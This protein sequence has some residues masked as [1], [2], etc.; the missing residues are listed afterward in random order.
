MTIAEKLYNRGYISYPRTETDV[1]EF[2]VEELKS[3]IRKQSNDP[4]FGSYSDR[5]LEGE[6]N[7]KA[8]EGEES[9]EMI[10]MRFSDFAVPR[11]GKNN[12]K[13]HPPI[14][15]TAAGADLSGVDRAVFE[16][17]ARRFLACCSQNAEGRETSVTAA[18]GLE[19]FDCRGI[20]IV[21][22]RYLDVYYP[23][24]KWT[25]GEVAPFTPRQQLPFQSFLMQQGKRQV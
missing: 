21:A 17:I 6:G 20:R 12:D 15:P 11:K 13:A 3:L 22:R 25:E 24:E 14:H 5:L 7:T 19:E 2:S 23:Y 9:E 1:F 8:E 4:Q 18:V 10:P 16:F